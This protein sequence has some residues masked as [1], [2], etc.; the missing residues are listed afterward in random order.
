MVKVKITN[1]IYGHKPKGVQCV[2]L[3]G[4]GE[5]VEVSKTEAKR[6]QDLGVVVLLEAE[7]SPQTPN[8]NE[9][10]GGLDDNGEMQPSA[11]AAADPVV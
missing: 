7:K 4:Y 2:Q 10:P 3:V 9:P 1:G 6:L 8:E 11:P 5:A